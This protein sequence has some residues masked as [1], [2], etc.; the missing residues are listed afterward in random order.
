MGGGH[1]TGD[2]GHV[3]V[4]TSPSRGTQAPGLGFL[5]N[6]GTFVF[7]WRPAA[8]VHQGLAVLPSVP[9]RADTAVGTQAID[10]YSLI[11]ARMRVALIDLV[12]AE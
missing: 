10:A 9:Q 3:A 7:T 11:E 6:A 2:I 4:S 12:E 8:E 1:L 5:L